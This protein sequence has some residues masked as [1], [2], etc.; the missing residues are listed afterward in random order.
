MG[1][2]LSIQTAIKKTTMRK[3]HFNFQTIAHELVFLVMFIQL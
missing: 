3:K 2:Y 1:E